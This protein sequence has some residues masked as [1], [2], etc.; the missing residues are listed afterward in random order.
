MLETIYRKRF[1]A[2]ELRQ[3]QGAWSVLVAEFFQQYV[4]PDAAIVDVAAGHCNFINQVCAREKWAIDGSTDLP[5]YTAADVHPVVS[6]APGFEGVP[7]GHFDVAFV[8]NFL[9]H[10]PASDAVIETLKRVREML[11][12]NGRVMILQPNFR[13][14]GAAYFDFIDH[15][16]VLTERSV[17]EALQI[18]GFA[19]L[20]R[21]VRFLPYTSKSRL[22]KSPALVRLYLRLPLAWL[23]LGKQSFFLAQRAE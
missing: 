4:P 8:S 20:R 17:E 14:L 3:L 15:K 11:R 5:K 13:L 2:E 10:L 19:V 12:P 21:I 7:D 6:F 23:L 18:A 16:V 9:E 22:S 1:E